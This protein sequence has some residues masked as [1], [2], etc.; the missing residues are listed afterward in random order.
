MLESRL[1]F[2]PKIDKIEICDEGYVPERDHIKILG[3]TEYDVFTESNSIPHNYQL[4]VVD[5]KI[6]PFEECQKMYYDYNKI[7]NFQK[8]RRFCVSLRDNESKHCTNKGI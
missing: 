7:Y 2:G 1:K 4:R 6:H 8:E 3:Y 5:S